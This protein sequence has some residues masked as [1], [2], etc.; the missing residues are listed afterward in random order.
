MNSR[1]NFRQWFNVYYSQNHEDLILRAML[2]DIT[3]GFY[4]DIGAHDP[5]YFS[6]T[7]L[8]YDAGW[9]GI[10]IDPQDIYYKK[11]MRSRKRDINL[12]CAIGSTAGEAKFREYPDASGLS[13]LSKDMVGAYESDA[14]YSSVT[15]NYKDYVV[16]VRPLS[17]VLSEYCDANTTIH[18]MKIDV[19]GYEKEVLL[20]NDWDRFRPQILCIEANHVK[21]DWHTLITSKGYKTIFHDGLNEYL[22]AQE[23]YET[24]K[25]RFNYAER[26]LR[27]IPL[28]FVPMNLLLKEV[29][30]L[31]ADNKTLRSLSAKQSKLLDERQKD[32]EFHRSRGDRL[33]DQ[34]QDINQQLQNKVARKVKKITVKIKRTKEKK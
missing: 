1:D 23:A 27:R 31:R 2:P 11:L 5:E 26:V 18:F 3:D 28:H 21:V 29:D 12:K 13:T 14:T 17:D 8:F 4:V 34:L 24:I 19:E 25:E 32:I 15:A 33:Q 9:H 30:D 22:V 20:G 7:K 6:V 16:A 10:N